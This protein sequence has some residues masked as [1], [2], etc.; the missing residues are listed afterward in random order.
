[1]VG[2]EY[3][4]DVRIFLKRESVPPCVL[5]A[6]SPVAPLLGWSTW[7]KSPGF[8]HPEDPHITFEEEGIEAKSGYA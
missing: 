2:I 1:M 3:E 5:G 6:K 7:I 8:T 4:F